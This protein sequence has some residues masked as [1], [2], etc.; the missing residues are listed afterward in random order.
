MNG[1]YEL[2]NTNLNKADLYIEDYSKSLG[3]E[4]LALLTNP[5]VKPYKPEDFE[6]VMI[7]ITSYS[8]HYTKLYDCL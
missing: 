8:I 7:V 1:K 3:N 2:S 5:M 6:A 4:A